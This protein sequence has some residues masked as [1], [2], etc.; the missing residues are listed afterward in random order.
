MIGTFEGPLESPTVLNYPQ[1]SLNS[2]QGG[3]LVALLSFEAL[4]VPEP[5]G[6]AL[7][8]AGVSLLPV[9]RLMRGFAEQAR[10][11]EPGDDALVDNR[12]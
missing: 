8:L 4:Q 6:L 9:H 5:T 1:L 10:C 7:L 11:S 2:L 3:G 12:G